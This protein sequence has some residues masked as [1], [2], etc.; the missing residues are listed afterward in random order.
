MRKTNKKQIIFV[1]EYFH[2]RYQLYIQHITTASWLEPQYYLEGSVYSSVHTSFWFIKALVVYQLLK[3]IVGCPP[4]VLVGRISEYWCNL[5]WI[6]THWAWKEMSSYRRWHIIFLKEN[7]VVK[8]SL[9]FV[10]DSPVNNKLVIGSGDGWI[11]KGNIPLSDS[12]LTIFCDAICSAWNGQS[13]TRP[14]RLDFGL[15]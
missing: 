14:I 9:K 6:L 11:W 10:P 7:D 13:P 3:A 5:P 4:L 15:S 8:S 2:S 12:V 1:H